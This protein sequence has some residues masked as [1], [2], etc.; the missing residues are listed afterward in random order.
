MSDL[1]DIKHDDDGS[2]FTFNRVVKMNA[3]SAEMVEEII[4]AIDNAH[5]NGARYLMFIGA[6]KNFCAGFDFSDV[7]SQ[8]D[9]DLLLRF[10]RIEMLLHMIA[11]SPCLTVAFA[12]GKTFGAGVDLFAVC[13]QRY[14]T[15]DASFRMPGLKF[16]LVL[17]SRRFSELVG[18][19]K[20]LDVLQEAKTIT[21]L[22]ARE[23]GLVND[24]REWTDWPGIATDAQRVAKALPIQAQKQLYQALDAE[25]P[26][27]DMA[28]L[29][30]SA[31]YPSLKKRLSEYFGERK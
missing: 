21:A 23:M 30:R 24:V 6:G 14:C 4:L 25:L 27:Q 16:G 31:A 3:L 15:P 9:G 8:S 1:L 18:R 5:S 7:E 19:A 12:H 17:G 20:A 10:V 2:T 29:V 28:N 13:K 26:D 11:S 22:E